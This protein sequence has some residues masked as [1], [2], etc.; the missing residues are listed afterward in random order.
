MWSQWYV[1]L[2]LVA[3]IRLIN[4]SGHFIIQLQMI[5]HPLSSEHFLAYVQHF[6]IVPQQGAVSSV[7]P[8]MG[9][10]MLQWVVR[11]DGSR[12]GGVIPITQVQSPTHLI[13]NFGKE[14]HPCLTHENSYKVCSKFWLNKYW[15]KE[16]YFTL[17]C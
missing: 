5:F 7:H 15:S 6:N 13:P 12:I 16:F 3:T 14:A 11:S 2:S 17:S 9:M 10:H 8:G 1:F 4:L